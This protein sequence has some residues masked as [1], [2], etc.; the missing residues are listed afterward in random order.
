MNAP[1][2]IEAPAPDIRDRLLHAQLTAIRCQSMAKRAAWAL[3]GLANQAAEHGIDVTYWR[4]LATD[5]EH[6]AEAEVI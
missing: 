5:I 1:A 3:H 4:N 6:R 2:R